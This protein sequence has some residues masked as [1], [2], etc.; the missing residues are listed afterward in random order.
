MKPLVPILFAAGAL[1]SLAGCGDRKDPS[2]A[3]ANHVTAEGKAEE[4]K[5][6]LKGPGVDLTFV[7][8]KGLRGAPK[9]DRNNKIFYP[10]STIGGAALVGSQ[11]EGKKQ[12]DSE[13]EFR[14]S[15][16]DPLDKVV[17]WY[18]D[19]ARRPDLGVTTARKEGD[20]IVLSGTQ[21]GQ[22]GE[23]DTFKVR[24]SKRSDGG[25]DGRLVVHHND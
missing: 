8:P 18:R 21:G 14:F 17:A 4:G 25:T 2:A 9:A 10:E 7:V 6:S 5:I 20:E 1:A 11:S 3:E 13:A 23:R 19:P 22:R 24:L 16:P 12:G 15:T